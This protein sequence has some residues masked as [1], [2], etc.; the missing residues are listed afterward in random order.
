MKFS[1]PAFLLIFGLA[2]HQPALG[3]EASEPETDAPAAEP[4]EPAA[5]AAEPTATAEPTTTAEAAAE[6]ALPPRLPLNELRV[7]AEALIGS[8]MP[9]SKKSMTALYLKTRLKVYFHNLTLIQLISIKVPFQTCRKPRPEIM[10]V[11]AWRLAWTAG[12]SRSSPPWTIHLP[13]KQASNLET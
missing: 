6:T 11:S 10:A 12:S 2:A 7:F 13:K 8:V 3:M 9:T 5:P 4:T 1:L